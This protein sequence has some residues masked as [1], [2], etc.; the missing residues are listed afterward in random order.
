MKSFLLLLCGVAALSACHK[1]TDNRPAALS[2]TDLLTA[3]NWRVMA[4]TTTTKANGSVIVTQVA[5]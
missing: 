5:E 1:D 2:R 3:K 4:Q